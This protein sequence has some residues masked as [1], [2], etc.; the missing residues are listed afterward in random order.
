LEAELNNGWAESVHPDDLDRCFAS[1]S[2]AF[3]LRETFHIE[4]RLRRADGEYRWVLCTGVP[5]FASDGVFEGYIGSDIDIT[6]LKHAQEELLARQKLESMGMLAGG[7]AHDFNNLLGSI[8]TTS[9]LVLSELPAGSPA[10]DWMQS[11][12]IVADR[13]AGIVRQMMSYAGQESPAFERVDVGQLVGEMIQLLKVSI[14]KGAT[15][16]TYVPENLPVVQANAAQIRQLLMNLVINASEALGE[17]EGAISVSL[18]HVHSGSDRDRIRLE[19]AD[20][21]C[22]MTEEIQRKMFDPFFTTKFAG[23]GLG[24][25]AVRGIV[26]SHGGSL[27][28]A[29]APGLG[30]RIQIL[31]PCASEPE[32][33]SR[34]MQRSTADGGTLT[35]TVLLVE[36]EDNLRQ[37]VSRM[38]RKKDL[39]VIE[40]RDG[41]SALDCFRIN[42]SRIDVVLLDMTLPGMPGREVLRE[43][44]RIRP[45]LKVIVTSAYG[46]DQALSAIGELQPWHYIRMPYQFAELMGLLRKICS[47]PQGMVATG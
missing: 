47:Q 7:I 5:R 9:E 6:D 38:L 18:A 11:I 22:G 43:V 19:I 1:H 14:S 28:V 34:A 45:D 29:T 13:G 3:D 37:A 27:D 30:C 41:K 25:A 16:R 33:A 8:L 36:D 12:K 21:G 24:L 31:L 46:M 40:A 39:N 10:L 17:K 23:R 42:A 44:R 2:S 35:G 15:L 20:T 26:R 32:Q 4:A